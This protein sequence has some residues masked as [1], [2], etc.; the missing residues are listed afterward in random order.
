MPPP[1]PPAE[2]PP[3]APVFNTVGNIVR[4][5]ASGG[6]SI[7]SV[8]TTGSL[9]KQGAGVL[10]LEGANRFDG[11]LDIE[12]GLVFTYGNLFADVDIARG[13]TL[14][15]M[16]DVIGDVVNDGTFDPM[17]S[18][19]E[20]FAD[21]DI[22]GNYSQSPEANLAA[23]LLGAQGSAPATPLLT[24]SGTATLAGTLQIAPRFATTLGYFEWILH[25]HGGIT[26]QFDR[27]TTAG[28]LF[29]TGQMQQT[30]NDV[31]FLA[32]RVSTQAVM[33]AAG[34]DA[35]TESSARA[36]RPRLQ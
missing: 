23:V 1:A 31:Y 7:Q 25:A 27:W 35:M 17:G 26:G 5:I 33:A 24:V 11:G 28:S 9:R 2:V 18:Y 12:Q 10:W 19:Y 13:S 32:S 16:G 29:I 21:A 6:E 14:E 34:A 22:F 8:S 36:G 30:S 4:L 20:D 3:A 15:L